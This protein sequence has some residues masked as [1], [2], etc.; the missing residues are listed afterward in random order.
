L[1]TVDFTQNKNEYKFKTVTGDITY[2][3]A[4]LYLNIIILNVIIALVG[5]VYER[6]M[7]V[8]KETEL[9]LKAEMLLELYEC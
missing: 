2:V 8:K 4:I 5:D 1:K 7:A 3:L 9:K 6:V